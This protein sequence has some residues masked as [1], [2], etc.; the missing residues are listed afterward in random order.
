LAESKVGARTF[1]IAG[2]LV[3]LVFAG[4][5]SQ[6]AAD[7]PD[8]LERVAEDTGFI[9][10]GQ[11]HSLADF[12]FADYATAGIANETLSLAVAGIVGTIVTLLV[13]YGLFMGLR[14][15]RKRDP[16]PV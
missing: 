2:V 16:A 14:E 4:V 3:A 15:T 12:V 13:V 8:G 11:D 10:S 6:F 9:D 5:V 7:D 1:V